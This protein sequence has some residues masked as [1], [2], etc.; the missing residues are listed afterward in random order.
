MQIPA[1]LAGAAVLVG[2]IAGCAQPARPAPAVSQVA[3]HATRTS[4]PVSRISSPVSSMSVACASGGPQLVPDR[5][6]VRAGDMIT[7]SRKGSWPIK[8]S[9]SAVTTGNPGLFGVDD[10]QWFRPLYYVF[11]VVSGTQPSQGS[12]F[13]PSDVAFA[14][15]E[16]IAG[17]GLPDKAL[18]I[19]IPDVKPGKY[20]I[21]FEYSAIHAHMTSGPTRYLL[22]ARVSV[23]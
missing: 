2:L 18:R 9:P 13:Q 22:C 5:H 11:A 8:G 17:T 1:K 10:D 21:Q 20:A 12:A 16:V 4:S 3:A 7:I 19:R 14:P 6:F 15:A 23:S